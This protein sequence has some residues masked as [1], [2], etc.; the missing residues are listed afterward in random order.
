[1]SCY[2]I[3]GGTPLAGAARCSRGQ[4]QCAAHPGRRPAGP[5][6]ERDPQLSGPVRRDRYPGHPAP[7]GLRGEQGGGHRRAGREGAGWDGDPRFPDG[8]AAVLCDLPG[9]AADPDGGGGAVL[10]WGLRT[11]PAA[12]RPPSGALRQLGAEIREEGGSLLCRR[13]KEM[14]GRELCLSLP[15]VGATENILLAACGCPG[16]TTL[17]GAAQEPEIVDLQEFLRAMGAQV[18]GAGTPVISI[19][20]GLPLHPAEHT[21]IGD[22][23]AAATYLCAVGAA[24]ARL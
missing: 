20:G 14:R 2:Q 3:N 19:E 7:A 24:G 21:V 6:R 4:E 10:P 16:R 8:G 9:G 15:S 5:R 23:I 11:G 22:R 13:G 12:H 18:E 17:V 1:M